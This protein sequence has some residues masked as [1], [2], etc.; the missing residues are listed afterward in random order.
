MMINRAKIAANLRSQREMHALVPRFKINRDEMIRKAH[1]NLFAP[2]AWP[3]G[4]RVVFHDE[5]GEV[6]CRDCAINYV[7]GYDV[8][9]ENESPTVARQM[10]DKSRRVYRSIYWEGPHEACSDCGKLL[11]SAYGDPDGDQSE[12]ESA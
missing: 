8:N 1:D 12:P 6:L 9:D 2:F 10:I 5:S 7:Y 11:E 3:G 4:Y